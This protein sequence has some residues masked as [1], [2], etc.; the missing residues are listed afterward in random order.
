MN[1]LK[2]F[3]LVFGISLLGLAFTNI[4]NAEENKKLTFVEKMKLKKSEKAAKKAAA[5]KAANT[6]NGT[7]LD[8]IETKVIKLDA[9]KSEIMGRGESCV[10]SL[11]TFEDV[12]VTEDSGSLLGALSGMANYNSE[13]V[14]RGG[15]VIKAIKP[16]KG[17]ITA[18]SRFDYVSGISAYNVQSI[19]TIMVKEGRFK[20]KQTN[21]KELLKSS[22]GSG[23]YNR[24]YKQWGTGWETTQEELTK[25]STRLASCIST[26]PVEEDW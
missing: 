11:V 15:E 22:S 21:I 17:T 9:S 14:I 3:I 4:S 10:E 8:S 2:T 5:E 7:Y 23:G 6:E 24:I 25:L 12:R 20:I 19:I 16:E 26:P 13:D 18:N 1:A